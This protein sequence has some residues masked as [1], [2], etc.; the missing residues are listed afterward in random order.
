[1]QNSPLIILLQAIG[2]AIMPFTRTLTELSAV[3]ALVAFT[4]SFLNSAI[5]TMIFWAAPK[6]VS[7]RFS[8][9]CLLPLGC[10]LCCQAPGAACST[11]CCNQDQCS[12]VLGR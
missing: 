5:F 9:P 3:F 7:K 1:M 8:P 4:F 12:Q 11:G 2:L 10:Q 6:S